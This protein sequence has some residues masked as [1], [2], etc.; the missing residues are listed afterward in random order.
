[1]T[2]R[3]QQ[4]IFGDGSIRLNEDDDTTYFEDEVKLSQ[5]TF[6]DVSYNVSK[7]K[8]LFL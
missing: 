7:L 6:D 4:K 2:M 1:M 8:F 5:I 3:R